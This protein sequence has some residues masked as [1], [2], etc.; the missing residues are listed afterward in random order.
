MIHYLPGCDV[1]KNHPEAVQ[2]MSEY[3]MMKNIHILECCRTDLSKVQSGDIIIH[4][5]TLCGLILNERLKNVKVMS[6][7]EYCLQDK[8][9]QWP[10]YSSWNLTIQDCIRTVDNR[11]LQDAIR[12]CCQH[13]NIHLLEINEN[14]EKTRYCGVWLNNPA[15]TLCKELAPQAFHALEKYRCIKSKEQQILDMQ[16]WNQQ[17]LT[18]NVIV[19]CNGCEKGMKLGDGKPIHM[20]ELLTK[21]L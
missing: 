1:R 16:K 7:Y 10:D 5:C 14:F 4:N 9:F 8:D 20:I 17:Y 18:K 2:K 21:E 11:Q 6:V 15:D 12:K 19:Y 13:M 3:M